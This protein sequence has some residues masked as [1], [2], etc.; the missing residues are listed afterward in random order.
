M[1]LILSYIA[2]RQIDYK[3][4]SFRYWNKPKNDFNWIKACIEKELRSYQNRPISLAKL[5]ALFHEKSVEWYLAKFTI[6]NNHLSIEIKNND[7]FCKIR[8]EA[9]KN[10]I[11]E[12][13]KAH[14]IPDIVFLVSMYDILT[15]ECT[16]WEDIP[17]FVMAKLKTD[18][19]KILIP[20]F[21]AL[22]GN[23]FFI[24]DLSNEIKRYRW[25]KKYSQA[26][27]RGSTTGGC[28]SSEN[29][30]NFPRAKAVHFSLENPELV[31]ARFTNLVQCNEQ[32]E[33]IKKFGNFFDENM[34]VK[35]QIRY[36]YQLLI[37]GNT[38]AYSRAFWQFFSNCAIFKQSSD[39]IQWY[40]GE[41]EP[42][43]HYI[44]LEEDLSDL[45]I[46]IQW[47]KKND[48]KVQKII[49]NAQNLSQ[50]TLTRK[51]IYQYLYQ[52]LMQYAKLEF[53]KN[54]ESSKKTCL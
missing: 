14:S 47:A 53:Q 17:I 11:T 12:F 50:K 42:Y 26:I 27:W 24:K 10:V 9:F 21:E 5:K 1:I 43:V 30:L 22:S 25:Q 44:P 3:N 36:K 7:D 49:Q 2:L 20:D 4:V 41:M 29:F 33:V 32:E 39:H 46:K 45:S 48:R 15:F 6:Q 38:C 37:D 18:T 51:A 13:L 34:P 40:Y 52:L 23:T 54:E 16:G 19:Q 28:I 35:K 31:N 8:A